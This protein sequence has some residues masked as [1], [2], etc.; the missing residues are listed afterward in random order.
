M[1]QNMAAEAFINH[2][3][4]PI[5]APSLGGVESLITRPSQT[6]HSGM[7]PAERERAGIGDGLIRLSVGLEATADLMAD[8]ARALEVFYQPPRPKPG[9]HALA[10]I[11]ATAVIGEGASIGPFVAVG[12]G[13]VIGRDAVIHPQLSQDSDLMSELARFVRASGY[14]C[15]S[16]SALDPFPSSDGFTLVCNRFSYK[17]AIENKNGR[18]TVIV[19]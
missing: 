1:C 7:P 10:S 9:I 5:C 16:I 13:V 17:Y 4:I 6:S 12:E 15:D 18:S 14:R 3:T 8:F 2:L 11:A 19:E